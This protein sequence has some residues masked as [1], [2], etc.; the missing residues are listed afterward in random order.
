MHG[1][2]LDR[3]TCNDPALRNCAFGPEPAEAMGKS[4]PPDLAPGICVPCTHAKDKYYKR[5]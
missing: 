4:L 2:A 5:L 1:K 3:E